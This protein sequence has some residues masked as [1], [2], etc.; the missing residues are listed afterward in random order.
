MRFSTIV[1]ATSMAGLA[2]ALPADQAASTYIIMEAF[3]N[4]NW[5]GSSITFPVMVQTECCM[6]S[7]CHVRGFQ[8][9]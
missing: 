9:F 8:E 1:T 7:Y 3:E 6:L 4:T 5:Q 2:H